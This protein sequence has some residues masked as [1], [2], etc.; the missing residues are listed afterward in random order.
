LNLQKRVLNFGNGGNGHRKS[1]I[2]LGIKVKVEKPWQRE[3]A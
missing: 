2:Q 1:D 3:A